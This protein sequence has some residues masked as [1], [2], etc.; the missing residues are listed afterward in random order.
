VILEVTGIPEAGA[1]HAWHALEAGKHVVMV[2]VEADVLL[3]LALK[4]KADEKKL[5]Y[6]MAYGDQPALICE[7]ID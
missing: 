1:Y 2:N 5:V 3:G 6:S 7:Q 4:K